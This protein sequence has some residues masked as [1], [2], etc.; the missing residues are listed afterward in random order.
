MK[1]MIELND[2]SKR[3]SFDEIEEIVI[4]IK[5]TM[6]LS[7]HTINSYHKAFVSLRKYFKDDNFNAYEMTR[8]E[9]DSYIRYLR[10]SYKHYSDRKNK[11][12]SKMGLS[13]RS[14]NTYLR[15]CKSI[16]NTLEDYNYIEN[17][18]FRNIKCLKLQ[19][20]R[21]KTVSSENINKF[22][23]SLDLRYYTDFRAYVIV[24]LLLDTMARINEVLNLKREDID[25]KNQTVYFSKT[26][27]NQ[28]R[29]VN[30]SSKTKR[31]LMKYYEITKEIESEYFFL[32]SH[33]KP[34]TSGA[35]RKSLNHYLDKFDI[36]DNF[37]CHSLRHT[38]ATEFLSNGGNIRVLQKILG[39][40]RI[41]TTEI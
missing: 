36:H 22:L 33:G 15:L 32:N 34:L 7:E 23:N 5:R 26:K 39:H 37:K 19:E 4:D 31:E 11:K 18:P 20:E 24:L 6:N 28:Y 38:G 14:V 21:V 2:Y 16:Y 41:T 8:E 1:R 30:F 27:N 3:N 35:F 12:G 17:N 13:V 40:S 25:F 10:Y 29:Y 9:A